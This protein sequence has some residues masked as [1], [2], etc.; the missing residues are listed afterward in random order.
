VNRY[1]SGPPSDHFDGHRFFNPHHP[2]GPTECAREGKLTAGDAL[3]ISCGALSEAERLSPCLPRLTSACVCGGRGAPPE[4][5][6]DRFRFSTAVQEVGRPRYR[7][8]GVYD[9]STA[10]ALQGRAW[11]PGRRHRSR[12]SGQPV[13]PNNAGRPPRSSPSGSS[14]SPPDRP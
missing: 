10:I 5:I 8:A 11:R 1:Y 2:D 13:S 6:D 9:Y 12:L 14:L 3:R 7:F 4:G